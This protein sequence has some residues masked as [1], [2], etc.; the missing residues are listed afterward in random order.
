MEKDG[1]KKCLT[2]TDFL[3]KSVQTHLCNESVEWE[4]NETEH[5]LKAD[6]KCLTS[7]VEA[8]EVWAGN[9]SE[10]AYAVLLLNRASISGKVEVSWSELG[11]NE[12]KVKI[13]DLWEKKDLGEFEDK[14]SVYLSS[15]DSV[16]LKIVPIEEESVMTAENIVMIVLGG[17]ILCGI[18]AFVIMYINTRKRN[19]SLDDEKGNLLENNDN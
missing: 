16:L 3:V 4:Y 1:I 17:V 10:G 7:N 19:K 2:T 14:Y 8:T 15:H 12:K 11:I 18:I 9:L 5:T 13:R 6:G